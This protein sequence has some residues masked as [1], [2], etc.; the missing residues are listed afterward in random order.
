MLK[1]GSSG[2]GH[3]MKLL[4]IGMYLIWVN[5]GHICV[6][7]PLPSE[8]GEKKARVAVHKLHWRKLVSVKMSN[9]NNDNNNFIKLVH[10][11]TNN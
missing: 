11:T 4:G 5:P 2:R 3:F 7:P 9:D 6:L 1:L 10:C 8:R